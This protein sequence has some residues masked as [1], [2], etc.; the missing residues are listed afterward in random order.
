[1]KT[2]QDEAL[3]KAM[4]MLG[5]HFDHI[6]IVADAPDVEFPQEDNPSLFTRY[7]GATWTCVGMMTYFSTMMKAAFMETKD[8]EEE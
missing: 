8:R 7:K 4:E 1:M 6:V 2:P 3:D 5:E